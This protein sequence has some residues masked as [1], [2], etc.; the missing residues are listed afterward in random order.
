M[1]KDNLAFSIVYENAEESFRCQRISAFSYEADGTRRYDWKAHAP[2]A[3][4][5]PELFKWW[6]DL[7]EGWEQLTAGMPLEPNRLYTLRMYLENGQGG[8][9]EFCIFKDGSVQFDYYGLFLD[10]D[11]FFKEMRIKACKEE[12]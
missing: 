8:D 9:A 7:G 6:Q 12:V 2:N 5:C 4:R 1:G 10:D 11:G 3:V